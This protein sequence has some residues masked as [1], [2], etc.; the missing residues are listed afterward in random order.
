MGE[1]AD[2]DRHVVETDEPTTR[3]PLNTPDSPQSKPSGCGGP[4]R[5]EVQCPASSGRGRAA[6]RMVR[7]VRRN[8]SSGSPLEPTIGFSRAVRVGSH[9]YV[10]ATAAIWPDG[11]VDH[12]VAA[13]T[14]RC[15]EIVEDALREAGA[16]L[17]D[18]VR[19]RVFLT[20][21]AHGDLV[22]AVHGEAFGS[23]R[24]A[25][26]FIVVRSFLDPRWLVEI[27]ADAVVADP[28]GQAA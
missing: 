10:A 13:Q 16:A 3:S 5:L 7:A 18:V 26:G 20:E 1:L 2:L 24:P 19:T 9:V 11:H 25:S 6:E 23:I 28:P 21:P 12:D 17:T 22:A 8:V 14:R 4:R 27:E 15:L